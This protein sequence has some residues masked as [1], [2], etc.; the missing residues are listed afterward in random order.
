MIPIRESGEEGVVRG[1]RRKED[2][3]CSD[4]RG[5]RGELRLNYAWH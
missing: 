5:V 2:M 3:E 1:T 4:F